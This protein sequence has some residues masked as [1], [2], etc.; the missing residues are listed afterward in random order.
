MLAQKFFHFLTYFV[1]FPNTLFLTK[2]VFMEENFKIAYAK[3]LNQFG[4]NQT[5]NIPI[6]ANANVKSVLD[7]NTYLFDVKVEC[8]SGKAILTGKVGAR[9]LYIDTDNLTNSVNESVSFT[10]TYVDS[11]I[12]SSS[13]LN[14]QN[15]TITNSLLDASSTLKIN[16]EVTFYPV[17]YLNL[18]VSPTLEQSDS[19]ITKKHA[20]SI[21]TIQQFVNTS[22]EQ[23]QVV[24][25]KETVNKI[26]CSNSHFAAENVFSE[27]NYAVVEGRLHTT[28]LVETN[29]GMKELQQESTVKTDVEIK[30]LS[31][32]SLLDLNFVVDKSKTEIEIE[33]EDNSSIITIKNQIL[34]CGVVM[35]TEEITLVD[36]VF[37]TSNTLTYNTAEREFTKHHETRSTTEVVSN[38]ISLN[39]TEP[40]IDEIVCNLNPRVEITNTYLKDEQIHIEGVITSNLTYVDENKEFKHRELESPFIVNTKI[41]ANSFGCVNSHACVLDTRVKVKRG[42]IID[43][44]STL[45]LTTTVYVKES[46]KMVDGIT[47]GKALE[48]NKYDFQIYLTKPEETCWDLCKRIKISP[49]QLTQLNKDLPAVMTGK[50]RVIIRR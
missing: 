40:A 6:D 32:D 24:E 50:E 15:H 39:S 35:K 1:P 29:E 20:F 44:E 33:L 47:L 34:V 8:G 17:E 2:G 19:L 42:T 49:D 11:Q 21:N 16:C 10:E 18:T 7:V 48:L 3:N 38:E 5:I 12:T 41:S 43:V 37:S 13:Y 26:L 25:S 9:V 14:V 23:T 28:L 45:F 4:F 36:D 46:C 30:D 27:N 22:F 31:K